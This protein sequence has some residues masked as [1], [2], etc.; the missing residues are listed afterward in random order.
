[1]PP[2]GKR[3]TATTG[4]T[5]AS[6]PAANH[7]NHPYRTH[8]LPAPTPPSTRRRG[9]NPRTATTPGLT[10][11][12]TNPPKF[13]RHSPPPLTQQQTAPPGDR[14]GSLAKLT[15]IA[16]PLLGPPG[17]HESLITHSDEA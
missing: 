10:P 14:H 1:M 13:Q 16:G 4:R 2:G 3:A 11:P 7:A 9:Q 15:S 17:E 5:I 8:G 6:R 12:R